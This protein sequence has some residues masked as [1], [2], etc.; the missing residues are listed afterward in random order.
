[1]E[2]VLREGE[3]EE[4]VR[5]EQKSRGVAA[6]SAEPRA[7]GNALR[8]RGP[9]PPRKRPARALDEEIPGAR[10]EIRRV[11]RD[12]NASRREHEPFARGL[13]RDLVLERDRLE[14]GVDLV[15]AV[16]A[17]PEDPEAEVDLRG[18]ANAK[19][20]GVALGQGRGH[21]RIARTAAPQRRTFTSV[22]LS[23]RRCSEGF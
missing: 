15:I 8:E 21:V 17:L 7:D 9:D 16:G 5:A 14:D 6:P 20:R 3:T 10:H 18:A 23:R 12:R 22:A 13:E 11:P 2:L 4:P 1:M 19:R